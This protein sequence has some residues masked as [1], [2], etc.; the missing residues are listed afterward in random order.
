MPSPSPAARMIRQSSRASPG[1]CTESQARCAR[2]SVHA[3]GEARE[4]WR[5]IRAAGEGLGIRL[6]FDDLEQLRARMAEAVPALAA[7]FAR[8]GCEDTAGPAGD[9]GAMSDASF[10][11]PI[12]Q[13][14]LA[15]A[16]ARAS[17]VM[18]ECGR[19]YGAQPVLQA[20]E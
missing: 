4:D 7:P 6:P 12:T 8:R 17:D 11:L 5:I 1:A 16:I 3:P 9:P 18:A 10:V 20:A 2:P 19:I 13:Y 15:D 14:H